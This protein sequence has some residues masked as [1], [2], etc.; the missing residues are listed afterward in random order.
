MLELKTNLLG[1]RLKQCSDINFEPAKYNENLI[2]LK[3]LM[4]P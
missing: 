3:N 1:G 4:E 2:V